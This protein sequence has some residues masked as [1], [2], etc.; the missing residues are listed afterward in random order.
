M[1]KVWEKSNKNSC[2]NRAEAFEMV[3]TLLGRDICAPDTIRFWVELRIK[4][5]KN[6]R[7]DDQIQE[8]LNCALVMEKERELKESDPPAHL[9]DPDH[10]LG[11]TEL[12]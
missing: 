10:R 3:F 11:A 9:A 8:A 2:L 1:R 6:K 5:G 7:D 12:V 4:T